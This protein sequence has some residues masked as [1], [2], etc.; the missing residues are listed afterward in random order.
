MAGIF[1]RIFKVSSA[2]A[3]SLV[4]KLEDPVKMTEQGI[5]DLKNDL[6]EALKSFAEVKAIGIRA[7]RDIEKNQLEAKNWERKAMALLQS[8]QSGKLDQAEADRL[9]G[10]A[11]S[12]KE[13][14]MKRAVSAQ[15]SYDGQKNHTQ[16]L[17]ANIEKLKQTISQT[18]NELITLKARSKTAT[19]TKKINKQ[20]SSIDSS[21][22]MSM[23]ERMKERVDEE[24]TLALAYGDMAQASTSIDDQINE[25]LKENQPSSSESLLALKAKMGIE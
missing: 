17:Q 1:S 5:R 10:E 18:E 21:G 4:D 9:A 13:E 25:A 16:T 3:H 6:A 12:R 8:A 2:E 19:A 23:L 20:L 24:E 15:A 11:L 14:S 22:T 7:Q